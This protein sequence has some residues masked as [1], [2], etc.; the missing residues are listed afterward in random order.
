MKNIYLQLLDHQLNN[1]F[2]I[3][4]TV[5]RTSGS[6]PQKPGSSAIF[7]NNGLITGTVGGGVVEGR[8]TELSKGA[9]R[10]KKSGHFL[11]NL[12]NDIS[13][14]NEAICGG[15]ISILIDSNVGNSIVVFEEMKKSLT[16]HIPGVLIT[17]VTPFSE[18]SVLINRYWATKKS[19]SAL[20][21]PFQKNI[22]PI[23]NGMI[24]DNHVAD[25]RET[26]LQ[27]PGEERSSIF[28]LE[29][30]FPPDKLIIAG[31]GH[32]GKAVA[33]LAGRLDF[34]TTIIDDRYE[35]ANKLNIPD[36]DH[37]IVSDIG[38][39]VKKLKKDI[40]T[41]VVIVTRGHKDDADAL[42]YCIGSDL[43]YTGMIGSK[44]KIAAM[45]S[46]FISNGLATA[47]QWVKVYTPIG[48]D[49]KSQTVEEIA[50]SI[51]A[52]LVLIRNLRKN[53]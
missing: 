15:Q 50:I 14:K 10:S 48:I 24:S 27:I 16:E 37:F 53:R 45:K 6:S 23:L 5:T 44:T 32:I 29:S 28:F 4:A 33:H 2:L 7:D 3:L 1:P 34:E 41:F 51:A 25:Y 40:N 18:D 9:V 17:K 26:E 42:R 22:E 31:A 46:D 8:V 20:P 43:A 49:I 11:F 19:V 13:N 30:V 39:S 38:E 12:T 35:F 36:A 21:E 47:E 52:Q